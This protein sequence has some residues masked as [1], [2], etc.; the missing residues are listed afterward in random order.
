[1]AMANYECGNMPLD[2]IYNEDCITGMKRLPDGCVDLVIADPPYN[3]GKA[4]WDKIP[5]YIEWSTKWIKECERLLKPCGVLYFW[6]SDLEQ[7]AQIMVSIKANTNFSFRS[8]CVWEKGN[9]FSKSWKNRRP[10]SATALRRWFQVA[11]YC[12]HYVK[13]GQ[14]ARSRYTHHCDADH[15]NVWNVQTQIGHKLHICQKPLDI[16]QRLVTVSS[17]P[18]DIVLDPFMGSGTT[19]IACIHTGRHYIGYEKDEEYY[20]T[21]LNRIKQEFSRTRH[22]E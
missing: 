9:Y 16:I 22:P 20:M 4:Y 17:D 8:F 19:A 11:E 18:E 6:H 1:M 21:G 7:L 12:L 13:P 14:G 5:D 15:K 2:V 3:I 10:D